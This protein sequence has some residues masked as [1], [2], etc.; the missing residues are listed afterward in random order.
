MLF[1]EALTIDFYN[2]NRPIPQGPPEEALVNSDSAHSLN[3]CIAVKLNSLEMPSIDGETMETYKAYND[4]NSLDLFNSEC[5]T[6]SGGLLVK[7][8]SQETL[9]DG[10]SVSSGVT[11]RQNRLSSQGSLSSLDC[12]ID[13]EFSSDCNETSDNLENDPGFKSADSNVTQRRLSYQ[14]A[15]NEDLDDTFWSVKSQNNSLTE[16]SEG[17]C[18][19][20]NSDIHGS[21]DYRK[22]RLSDRLSVTGDDDVFLD[23]PVMK[24][25]GDYCWN[26]N[27]VLFNDDIS[28]SSHSF[29]HLSYPF[30]PLRQ[31]MTR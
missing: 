7:Q 20:P 12:V 9:C 30:Q 17:K 8:H 14:A 26:D 3:T 6:N 10:S 31:D 22:C 25:A 23:D 24:S 5:D 11:V 2:G 4:Q 27:L 1:L 13:G 15:I 21:G 29:S 18:F 16:D 19:S 28:Y